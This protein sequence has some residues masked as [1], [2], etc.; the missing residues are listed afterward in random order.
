MAQGYPGFWY[1]GWGTQSVFGTAVAPQIFPRMASASKGQET[2]KTEEGYDGLNRE[3]SWIAKVA[4]MHELAFASQF[5]PGPTTAALMNMFGIT[6]LVSGTLTTGSSTLG[7]SAVIGAT[8]VT[9]TASTGY[10]NGQTLLFGTAG[11][12][13]SELVTLGTIS[14]TTFPI[15]APSTGLRYAHA[16][17]SS[18]LGVTDPY[19]HTGT[20]TNAIPNPFSFEHSIGQ[21]P[22]PASPLDV[23]RTPDG[24]FTGIKLD[25]TGG[26]VATA[27][28]D[29][30]GRL[31]VPG[32]GAATVGF[33]TDAPLVLSAPGTAFTVGAYSSTPGTGMDILTAN[34][35]QFG[36]D[37]KLTPDP[38]QPAGT[39]APYQNATVRGT[40][41]NCKVWIPSNA[42]MREIYY[43]SSS[44]TTPIIQVQQT[45]FQVKFDEQG[46][47]D[48][49]VQLLFN[50]FAAKAGM[51]TFSAEGKAML[52][53]LSGIAMPSGATGAL[54]ITSQTA[55]GLNYNSFG[56]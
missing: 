1:A 26:K 9:M 31:G 28:F 56:M 19:T 49:Y 21:Q 37:T 33:T 41:L 17:G 2:I 14:G 16:S 23:V 10:S 39:L 32:G 48:H 6:D 11:S 50:Q 54:T 46:T 4:Q 35:V 43:G 8:S 27:A 5:Y 47:P 13:G 15:I 12:A 22:S 44:G 45:T 40:T 53:T 30:A 7:A 51:P 25:A 42:L 52:F 29:I 24:I 3:L 20:S 36:M 34:V 55:D 38:V 18:V